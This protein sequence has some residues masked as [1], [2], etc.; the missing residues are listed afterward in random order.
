MAI[1]AHNTLRHGSTAGFLTVVGVE[2]GDACLL[3]TTFTALRLFSEL[4][5]G[6]LRWLSLAG[7]LYLVWLAAEALLVRH[8]SARKPGM[9][10][11]RKPVL[12]G[13]TIGLANPTRLLFYT[14][15]FPQFIDP[16]H[17]T[18]EQMILLSALFICTAV[19]LESACVLTVA[20]LRPPAGCSAQIGRFAELGS[21]VVYLSIA[22]ITVLGFIEASR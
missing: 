20:R 13:L 17:S 7:S 6:L 18:S 14:A 19:A 22:V 15:F 1:V 9:S 4:L 12:S 10:R 8:D 5:P 2:L 3:G 11:C 16:D 21:A